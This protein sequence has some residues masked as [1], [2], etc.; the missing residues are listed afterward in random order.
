LKTRYPVA[1]AFL[2]G[3]ALGTLAIQILHAETRSPAYVV[4]E[5]DVMDD[6][7]YE[8]TYV[9]LA[10]K[11]IVDAGGKYIVRG[12]TSLSF[13]GVPPKRIAII[14][15]E[16]LEKAEAAFNS[17]AYKEAKKAG[18]EYANFRMYA[19]EGVAR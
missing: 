13:F 8:K 10:S 3:V 9:P 7:L 14:R 12:G 1:V 17:P 16:S 4:A 15:F 18:D 11:A 2:A 19:I 5:I 6:A